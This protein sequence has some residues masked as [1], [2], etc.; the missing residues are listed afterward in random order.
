MFLVELEVIISMNDENVSF[1]M[2]SSHLYLK[3]NFSWWNVFSHCLNY[4]VV[5]MAADVV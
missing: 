2:N 4:V 5:Q 3:C 1:Y